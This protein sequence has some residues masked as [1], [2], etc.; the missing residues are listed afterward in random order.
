[1]CYL[2][3]FFP[4][5][6]ELVSRAGFMLTCMVVYFAEARSDEIHPESQMVTLSVRTIQA[7]ARRVSDISQGAA[8]RKVRLEGNIGDL[9]PKLL[10]LPFDT[11]Q[12]LATKE[13]N[14]AL[15]SRDSMQ[16]PNGHTL[17]FRPIYIDTKRLSIWLHWRDDV[18]GEILNTRVHFDASDAVLT[19]T[20]YAHDRGLILAIKPK[21][22]S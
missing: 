11:F 5:T 20:D 3:S 22:G 14:I 6:K 16:L 21:F 19:G 17:T 2:R 10:Q 15:M 4:S 12:L 13:E 1:M 18:G 9:K 7:S 8:D